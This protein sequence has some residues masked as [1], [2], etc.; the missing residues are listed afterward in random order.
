[1]TFSPT[2]SVITFATNKLSYVKLALNCAQSILIHND[3]EIFIVSNLNFTVPE[4][5]RKNVSVVNAKIEHAELGIGMKLYIDEYLQTK[6]SLFIDSDC[7]C[8]DSLEPIF[9]ACEG[10]DV[11][12]VGTTVNAEEWCGP[13]NAAAVKQEFGITKLPRF[14][15]GLYYLKKSEQ[16]KS[17]Y[18]LAQSLIPQYDVLGFD[19]LRNGWFNEEILIAIAMTLSDQLPIKDNGRFMTDLYTDHHPSLLNVLRGVRQLKNPKSGE[20]YHRPW[21]PAGTYSPILLHFGGQRLHSF[22]YI[23]QYALLKLKS[24][25]IGNTVSSLTSKL[26]LQLPYRLYMKLKKPAIYFN[27]K[28][29]HKKRLA[30]RR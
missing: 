5:L 26:F 23:T 10:M 24:L 28:L 19:R 13:A 18:R 16:T 29:A 22:P 1:M 3:I 14:N 20:L 8:Y 4:Y 30:E 15:G 12:V 21:Y 17:I 11:T 27:D 6:H 9:K 7:L 25:N 2:Y